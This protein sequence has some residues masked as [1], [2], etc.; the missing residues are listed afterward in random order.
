MTSPLGLCDALALKEGAGW[1]H[2]EK[3]QGSIGKRDIGAGHCL[4]GR[5]RA[6]LWRICGRAAGILPGNGANVRRNAQRR[7]GASRPA[8]G[9]VPAAVW[10]THSADPAG[11]REG[12]FAAPA[13][14]A[15]AA[16]G[17]ECGAQTGARDGNG[18]G[19]ILW[20]GSEPH[21]GRF[22]AGIA[23]QAGG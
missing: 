23:E 18:G 8:A 14:V 22:D 2:A 4:G 11:E 15:G 10:R 6:H 3:V 17:R 12:I 19:A 5:G 13:G 21:H 7:G 16:A 20:E 9:D 1:A